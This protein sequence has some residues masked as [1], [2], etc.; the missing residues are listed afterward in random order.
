MRWIAGDVRRYL[1]LAMLGLGS[2][3]C[4][5]EIAPLEEARTSY[6]AL[7]RMNQIQV[8]GSHNS[9]KK[10]IDASLLA[11]LEEEDPETARALEYSHP[12]L[13]EQLE[14]GLR[15]LE[16]DLYYDPEGGRYANPKGLEL[17]AARGMPPGSPYDP[18]RLMLQPGFK[19]L[20]VQ[21][22]DFRS[23][24]L[25]FQAALMEIR[26]WS[27]AHPDH[28]PIV[29]TINAKDEEVE[30][31]PEFVRPLPY[32]REAFEALEE[33]IRNVF[34]EGSLI[35]PDDVRDDFPTL[36]QAVLAGNWP[37]LSEARGKVLFVLDEEGRKQETYIGGHPSLE[38][39]IL[40]VNAKEGSP[41]AAFRIVN[42]PIQ[43][44]DYIRELVRVGYLVR[45]RA[46]ADTE[47]ARSE[48]TRRREAAFASGA[49]F[50]STDYYL[51]GRAFQ[52]RYRVSFSERRM[53]RWN[54]VS[55]P[56]RPSRDSE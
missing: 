12:S 32:D 18:G 54:P 3:V 26:S 31:H 48:D 39:L 13:P 27:V 52:S 50:I 40:F 25:T 17:V 47:E 53:A 36:E 20:H 23:H 46:D 2:S 9:Y 14:I 34:S 45:T 24:Y 35:T 11:I 21:D 51:P 41:E 10:P 44:E 15:Q 49:H 6:D 22:L 19:V 55:P 5:S 42:D 8:I 4:S 28:L 43:D 30:E 16:L 38:G 1:L 56:E 29:I 37:T 33:E 7:V